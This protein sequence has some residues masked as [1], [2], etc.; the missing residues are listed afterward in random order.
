VTVSAEGVHTL[1]YRST[2]QAGNT[3]EFVLITSKGLDI[4]Y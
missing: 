3:L 4:R 2:D 1:A